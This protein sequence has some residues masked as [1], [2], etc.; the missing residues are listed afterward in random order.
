M[1]SDTDNVRNLVLVQYST[2]T[3]P[4]IIG[5]TPQRRITTQN[6]LYEWNNPNPNN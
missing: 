6:A 3:K 4:P 1:L 5:S 2:I